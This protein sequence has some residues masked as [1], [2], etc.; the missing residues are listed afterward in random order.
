M[1]NPCTKASTAIGGTK[2]IVFGMGVFE[3]VF[4]LVSG[5]SYV[6]HYTNDYRHWD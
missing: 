1:T 2:R 3:V 5:G 4:K 6:K